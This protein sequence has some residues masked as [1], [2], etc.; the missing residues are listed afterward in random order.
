MF[1]SVDIVEKMLGEQDYICDKKIATV[2]FLAIKLESPSW[3][4][5]PPVS[6]R[7]SWRRSWPGPRIAT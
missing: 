6:A 1:E 5:D 7:P 2:V 4:R 3:S